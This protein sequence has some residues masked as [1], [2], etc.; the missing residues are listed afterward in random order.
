MFRALRLALL[1]LLIAAPAAFAVQPDELLPD[2][3]LEARA[4]ALSAGLRCLVCQN[5]SIDDSDAPLAKDIRVLIRE[6]ISKGESNDEVRDF[7]VSRYGDFILLKP[8]LKPET[9]LLWLSAPLT[10]GLGALAIFYAT[11]RV[12]KTTLALSA[13]EERRLA[14]IAGN[15]MPADRPRKAKR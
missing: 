1:A 13:D 4:R 14:E 7:L 2:S 11:R 12:P 10:L 5:Q 8:P 6:R 3:A 15:T 9:W